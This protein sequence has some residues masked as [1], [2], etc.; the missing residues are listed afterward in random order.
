VKVGLE[1][2]GTH[3]LLICADDVN[4]LCNHINTVKE[5]TETVLEARRDA[6]L[7][8]DA[9]ETKYMNMSCHLNL[10]QDQNMMNCLKM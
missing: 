7:E 8:I 9:E 3:Q 2:N 1:L 5:S 4:L 10:G 6:G